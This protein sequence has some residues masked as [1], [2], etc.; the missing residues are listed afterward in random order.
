MAFLFLHCVR[1]MD[2]NETPQEETREEK[3]LN[4]IVAKLLGNDAD[5]LAYNPPMSTKSSSQGNTPP[6][7]PIFPTRTL[8]ETKNPSSRKSWN[9]GE[10][11][12]EV[13]EDP[14]SSPKNSKRRIVVMP[15]HKS[16]QNK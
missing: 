13:Q 2:E 7:S 15:K 9:P 10:E 5:S 4:Q 16:S 11:P 6:K 12:P 1:A 8:Q 3:I 14:S